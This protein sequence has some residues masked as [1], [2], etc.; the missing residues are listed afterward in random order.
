MSLSDIQFV[1]F[2]MLLHVVFLNL[3]KANYTR[4]MKL[5]RGVAAVILSVVGFY[6]LFADLG[7]WRSAFI[8][9]HTAGDALESKLHFCMLICMGHF[10]ADL[11]WLVLG[12][13]RYGV[14]LRRDLIIHHVIGII[15]FGYA[16]HHEIAYV[17]CLITMASEVMPVTTGI[18]AYGQRV[19]NMDIVRSANRWRLKLLVWWRVPLWATMAILSVRT[20]IFGAYPQDLFVAYILST[21]GFVGLL[22]LDRF[23]IKQCIAAE[24]NS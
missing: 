8:F 9:H 22:L 18:G 14:A 1:A 10:V 23:W 4:A 12:K 15:A 2:F 5:S 6:G 3:P 11:L 17:A 13:M 20:L 24:S 16:L 7:Q 19:Q 21:C